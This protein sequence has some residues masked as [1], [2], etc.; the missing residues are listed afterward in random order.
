[1]LGDILMNM[2]TYY[3]AMRLVNDTVMHPVPV[4]PSDCSASLPATATNQVNTT[5]TSIINI[6]LYN[7][8]ESMDTDM[9]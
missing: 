1:M 4:P 2:C 3:M 6:N 5:D 8:D 9:I 7:C